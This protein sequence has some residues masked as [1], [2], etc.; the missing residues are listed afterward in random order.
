MPIILMLNLKGGVAKTTIALAE[1][2]ATYAMNLR[3]KLWTSLTP[4][5]LQDR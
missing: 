1:C 5:G 3:F 4:Q 2:M